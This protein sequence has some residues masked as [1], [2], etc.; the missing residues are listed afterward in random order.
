[1]VEVTEHM[2][3]L[4]ITQEVFQRR[5]EDEDPG[6]EPG[7]FLMP[8]DIR[9]LEQRRA[10]AAARQAAKNTH[11]GNGVGKYAD[12]E[13]EILAETEAARQG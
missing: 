7:P 9:I 10:E 2:K 5:Q 4:G 13:Q 8:S 11:N 3:K 1:M 6:D 12:A